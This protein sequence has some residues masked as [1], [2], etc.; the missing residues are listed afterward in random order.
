MRILAIAT[1]FA[2]IAGCVAPP[3][4]Y[5]GTTPSP[6]DAAYAC[7]LRQVNEL[8]YTVIAADKASGFISGMKQTF[9]RFAPLVGGKAKRDQ[10]NVAVYPA[11]SGSGRMRITASS[12]RETRTILKTSIDGISPSARV[13]GDASAILSACTDGAITKVGEGTVARRR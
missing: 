3:A 2:S 5:V 10:L 6:T 12:E 13:R 8:G 7:A 9:G 4:V 1:V 11:D